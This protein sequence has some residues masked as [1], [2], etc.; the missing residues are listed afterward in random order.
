MWIVRTSIVLLFSIRAHPRLTLHVGRTA[1]LRRAAQMG[2]HHPALTNEVEIESFSTPR[3]GCRN[4]EHT[5]EVAAPPRRPSP[6]LLAPA[7]TAK[8]RPPTQKI[9]YLNL[10]LNMRQYSFKDVT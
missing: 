6:T 7:T 4:N 3:A 2:L 1:Q 9:A 5:D 8:I 10:L